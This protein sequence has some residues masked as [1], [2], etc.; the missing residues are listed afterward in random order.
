MA[1][2]QPDRPAGLTAE[3]LTQLRNM[4]D[5]CTWEGDLIFPCR[6]R[7]LLDALDTAEAALSEE[8]EAHAEAWENFRRVATEAHDL[9]ERVADAEAC[10]AAMV[11]AANLAADER[12]RLAGR[13][14]EQQRVIDAAHRVRA[15]W[16]N[17]KN[18]DRDKYMLRLADEFIELEDALDALTGAAGERGDGEHD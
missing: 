6:I 11:N 14:A 3:E 16:D 5:K 18:L 7:R 12:D 17:D 8:R 15:A 10:Y 1:I 4:H 9:A 13:V 2:D